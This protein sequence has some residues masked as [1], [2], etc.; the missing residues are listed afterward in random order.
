MTSLG[1][2]RTG[3]GAILV[4][5]LLLTLHLYGGL[6]DN[7]QALKDSYRMQQ[8]IADTTLSAVAISHRIS[9]E[10]IDAKRKNTLDAQAAKKDVKVIL[11]GNDC[12]STTAPGGLIDRM[13]QYKD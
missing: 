5:S 12:A 6:K 13:R 9:G 2:V 1:K 11:M 8:V 7:Y 3:I 10:A 4:I